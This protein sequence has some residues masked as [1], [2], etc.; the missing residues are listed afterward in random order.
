[1]VNS[2]SNGYENNFSALYPAVPNGTIVMSSIL[3]S[4]KA[5]ADNVKTIFASLQ[6]ILKH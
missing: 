4:K 5:L 2:L 6:T 3:L 1:V